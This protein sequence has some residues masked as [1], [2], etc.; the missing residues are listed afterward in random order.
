MCLCHVGDR[1]PNLAVAGNAGGGDDVRYRAF[2][3]DPCVV[4][5]R[6]AIADPLDLVELVGLHSTTP[7][8]SSSAARARCPSNSS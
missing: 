1:E 2:G 7:A 5:D 6:D 8:P 4:H 3:N